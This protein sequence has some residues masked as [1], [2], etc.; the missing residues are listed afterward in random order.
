[1][2]R[3]IVSC[4]LIALALLTGA[5]SGDDA[6]ETTTT[7]GTTA[8]PVTSLAATSGSEDTTTA[9]PTTVAATTTTAD[10]DSEPVFP[11]Y[12]IVFREDGEAGDTV[13]VL[14]DSNAFS[15]TDID[16]AG[17][18]GDVVENFPPILT[19]YVVDDAAAAEAVLVAEPT[20]EQQELLDR[21][22]LVRLEEGFR[23]IF[24]GPF[25]DV[26]DVILGS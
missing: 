17:V 13:V 11:D 1:M 16:L 6:G 20:A 12:E 8:A 22:Y 10:P 14:V 18:L 15:L 25:A 9:P 21:H 26:P 7:V 2:T 24:A 4:C 3:T 23:M 19:A 5:C